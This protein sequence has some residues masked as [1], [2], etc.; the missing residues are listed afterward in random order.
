[1]T[2]ADE[3]IQRVDAALDVLRDHFDSVQ[4]YCTRYDGA[5]GTT[6][7]AKGTGNWFARL[8]QI[9]EWLIKMDEERRDH[10]RT[11]PEPKDE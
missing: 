8:G 6:E 5:E 9:R 3:D 10:S 1:M 11:K 7:I 2:E 4:I